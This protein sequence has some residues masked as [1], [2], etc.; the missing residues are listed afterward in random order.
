MQC[1]QGFKMQLTTSNRENGGKGEN[2]G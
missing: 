2:G 1:K